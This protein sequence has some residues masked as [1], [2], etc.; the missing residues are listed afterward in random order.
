MNSQKALFL[1]LFTLLL[2]L[3][4]ACSDGEA[5][6][7]GTTT[8]EDD[9]GGTT[10]TSTGFTVSANQVYDNGEAINLFGINWFG[11]ETNEHV[12]HGLWERNYEEVIAQMQELGFNAMRIPFCPETLAPSD[13]SSIDYSINAGLT[14]MNSLELLDL[15]V[16]TLDSYNFYVLLDH[17]RPDC[18]AISEL[19]YTD[20]Y[21]EEDW[22]DDLTFV[23]DRYAD[24]D[25]FLG[26]D[27]KNEPHESATWGTGDEATDWNLAAE[28]AADAILAVN[29]NILIFVEGIQENADCSD[30]TNSHWWGGNIEPVACT[31]LDIDA[32]RLVLSPHVYG[33]DVYDQSYFSDAAFPNNMP[34]IWD[35]QFGFALDS[36]YTVIPGEFGGKYGESDARDDDW[37]DAFVDY[38]IDNNIC[39]FFFWSLNPNSGDTGGILDD[40]WE[41]VKEGKYNNLKR[42]MDACE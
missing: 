8:G 9:G 39:S 28:R 27:L 5:V 33:P 23:A 26:I 36:G 22:I 12:V 35:S 21:S 11:F 3:N 29:P 19:W 15:I 10:P 34:A 16:Q 13:P 20:D 42:L 38:M 17:H 7:G 6:F 24:F 2:T 41:T 1:I 37:Q 4:A 30:G 31:P 32:D 25:H 14:D 40:D 18:E